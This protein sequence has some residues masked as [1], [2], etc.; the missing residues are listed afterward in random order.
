MNFKTSPVLSHLQIFRSI[1]SMNWFTHVFIDQFINSKNIER[2]IENRNCNFKIATVLL[3]CYI[4]IK[5]LKWIWIYL[6]TITMRRCLPNTQIG[7]FES[8]FDKISQIWDKCPKIDIFERYATRTFTFE[9][10]RKF[11][12][13]LF[14]EYFWGNISNIYFVAKFTC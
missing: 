2:K 8:Y 7:T 1:E 9:L 6:G 11:W 12:K 10:V 3:V 14:F 5:L 13:N 4:F